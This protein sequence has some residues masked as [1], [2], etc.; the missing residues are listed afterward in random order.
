MRQQKTALLLFSGGQ[1]SCTCLAY[2][3]ANYAHVET[4]GFAYGQ[5]HAIEMQTRLV[6]LQNY[7]ANFADAA[8]RLGEDHLLDISGYADIAHSSLTKQVADTKRKDGLPATYVPGRNLIFLIA[9]AALAERRGASVLVAGMCETDYSGYPDCRREVMDAM[10]QLIGL[11]MNLQMQIDTPLMALTK[12]QTWALA[13]QFGGQKLV[14]MIVTDSHSC[15][16]GNRETL[17][18]WGYGC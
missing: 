17:H 13:H 4:I 12:A 8:Q 9:A 7:R 18:N 1:D 15:Y 10:E 16:Q 6:F 3:L 2:A 11:G 14:D 5:A